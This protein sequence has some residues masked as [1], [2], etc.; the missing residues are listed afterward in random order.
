MARAVARR[1]ARIMTAVVI[2]IVMA[3]AVMTTTM[4]EIYAIVMSV[5]WARLSIYV[6]MIASTAIESTVVMMTGM[7]TSVTPIDA[8]GIVVEER[9][10]VI[11]LMD[12]EQP[13]AAVSI[14]GAIEVVQSQERTVLQLIHN[15]AQ[16]LITVIQVGIVAIDSRIVSV[17][18][19]VHV[20]IDRAKEIVVD[21]VTILI[22]LWGEVQ[23]VSHAVAQE[24]GILTDSTL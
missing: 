24:T 18:D 3:I 9:V 22:L 21:F 8:R 14:D 4:T 13:A 5:H 16:I 2:T 19:I 17:A 1:M 11:A 7:S 10:V 6:V 23:F 12:A 20:R 15:V